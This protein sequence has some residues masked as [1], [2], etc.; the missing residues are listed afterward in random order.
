FMG[1]VR[2][3]DVERAQQRIVNVIRQLEDSGDI[4]IARGGEEEVIV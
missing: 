3:K 2:L 4:I 1:P